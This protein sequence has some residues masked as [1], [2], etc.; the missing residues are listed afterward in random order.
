MI[1]RWLYNVFYE[2]M[3]FQCRFARVFFKCFAGAGPVPVRNQCG[4]IY[5]FNTMRCA[6]RVAD[7]HRARPCMAVVCNRRQI[8]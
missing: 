8:F 6:V 7:G 5:K 4:R 3:G 1:I 2:L